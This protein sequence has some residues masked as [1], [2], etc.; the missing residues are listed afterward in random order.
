[1]FNR[2]GKGVP[3][4]FI[5]GKG[6]ALDRGTY[7]DNVDRKLLNE[8]KNSQKLLCR[9]TLTLRCDGGD[10]LVLHCDEV[11]TVD[12]RQS[13]VYIIWGAA[14]GG[15]VVARIEALF[16]LEDRQSQ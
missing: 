6:G 9:S 4:A 15:E 11:G 10:K 8:A 14:E 3:H 16:E 12:R 13:W 7:T 5:F 2:G 1:M